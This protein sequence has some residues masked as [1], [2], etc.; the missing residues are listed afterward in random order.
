[1]I[2]TSCVQMKFISLPWP[3]CSS[4]MDSG[5]SHSALLHVKSFGQSVIKTALIFSYIVY[6]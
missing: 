1:M 4:V 2:I 3:S 5:S 6:Q